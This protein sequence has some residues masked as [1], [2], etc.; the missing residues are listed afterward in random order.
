M[1]VVF[2]SF[3]SCKGKGMVSG[4]GT[5]RASKALC[6]RVCFFVNHLHTPATDVYPQPDAGLQQALLTTTS[7]THGDRSPK[8]EAHKSANL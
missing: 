1:S 4:E 2:A 7:L 5:V 6:G 3:V 8:T